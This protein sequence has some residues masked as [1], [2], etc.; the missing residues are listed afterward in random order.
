MR[1]GEVTYCDPWVSDVELDETRYRSV[2]WG[3]ETVDAADCVVVLTPHRQ[4]VDEPL[5]DRARLVVD[6]RNVV[7]PG[8]HVW[9]I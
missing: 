3:P 6:T 5:W 8:P 4:F 1:G 7:P 9:S 2:T